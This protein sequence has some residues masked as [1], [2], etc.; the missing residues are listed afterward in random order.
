MKLLSIEDKKWL[1]AR[2]PNLRIKDTIGGFSIAGNLEVKMFYSEPLGKYVVFPEEDMRSSEYYINDNYQ[3]RVD[4]KDTFFIPEVY[5]TAGRIK[6]FAERKNIALPDLHVNYR[7]NLCLC[8]KPLEKVILNGP[9]T[10]ERFFT[11]LVIPFFY[12]QSYYEKF[13]RWPWKDYSHGDPGILECYADHISKVQE[14]AAF[15]E[16]TINSLN[17]RNQSV[18]RSADQITRQSL[19]FC[20]SGKKFRSCHNEAWEAAK[21]LKRTISNSE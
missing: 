9:Y 16:S 17:S 18:V 15:V 21:M 11:L 12:A 14:K 7:G 8:P 3:V 5:E 10:I 13:N 2:F 19:C 4:Y 6:A 1:N 20:G